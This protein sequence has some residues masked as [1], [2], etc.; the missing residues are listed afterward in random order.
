[1]S[2]PHRMRAVRIR[3]PGGPEML[4]LIEADLPQPAPG[5][6]LVR[7]AAAG[8][9]RPDLLQRLGRYP[10]PPGTNPLPGLEIA[11]TVV[12][13]A[14][15]GTRWPAG[16]RVMALTAGGGY[17]EFC[18]VHESHCLPVPG[19]MTL[20]QAATVPETCFTVAYNL[21]TRA[22][23][24]AGEILLVHGGSGGIGSTAIQLAKA[25]GALVAT[26]AG[27]D[28]KCAFCRELGAD[29]AVNYRNDDWEAAVAAWL[30]SLDRDGLDVV[31]DMI[32]GSYFRKNLKL[33]GQNG[34]Y[35]LIAFQDGREATIDAAAVLS[36]RLTITGST[37][38]PR[39]IEEKAQ[40]ARDVETGVLPLLAAGDIRPV[41]TARFPLAD[42]RA[43]HELME[44]GSHRGKIVLD[45]AAEDAS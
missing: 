17:A 6:V 43:A 1:M 30:D 28:E 2:L 19:S 21:F 9:N 16:S 4:E 14:D 10:L 31:L 33:L 20:Q 29:L 12:A 42:A 7:V 41:V 24:G 37:L 40:I 11:G 3:E 18:A 13:A 23:L 36:K 15:D 25:R 5:E 35:S 38:R 26:T 39:T 22:A 32:A 44:S 45:V 27:T 8:V 34:R